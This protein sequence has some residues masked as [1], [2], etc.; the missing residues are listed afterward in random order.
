MNH[1]ESYQN[2]NFG[3]LQEENDALRG[4]IQD[5]KHALEFLAKKHK[6][7]KVYFIKPLQSKFNIL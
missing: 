2:P 5:Y 3:A 6:E 1:A 7:L 4:T